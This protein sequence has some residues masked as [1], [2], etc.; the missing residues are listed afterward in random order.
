MSG[1]YCVLSDELLETWINFKKG[2]ISDKNTL[3]KLLKFIKYPFLAHFDKNSLL[4]IS[5]PS[6]KQ[7]ILSTYP[8]IGNINLEELATNT[9]YKIIFNNEN[10][11]NPPYFDI[12][13][14]KIL[15][16]NYVILLKPND[17]KQYIKDY[18]KILLLKANNIFIHDNYISNN[19]NICKTFF[20]YCLPKHKLNIFYT[21]STFKEKD[22]NI[23]SQIK[24]IHLDWKLKKSINTFD[25]NDKSHD[26]YLIIDNKLEIILS[27]G[28]DGLFSNDNESALIIRE[29]K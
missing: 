17:N 26:R 5:E 15:E 6:L 12:N 29:L 16:N 21:N 22:H 20:E 28:F 10:E 3:E 25:I 24:G 11:N 27:S 14:N 4:Q 23:L 18:L 7:A 8:S 1:Y 19:F 13:N 9:L 2:I